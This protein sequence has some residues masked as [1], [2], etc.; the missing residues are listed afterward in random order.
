MAVDH[1]I[2]LRIA[3]ETVITG[4]TPGLYPHIPFKRADGRQ[5]LAQLPLSGT[6]DQST[7]HFRAVVGPV[8]DQGYMNGVDVDSQVP[9]EVQVRYLR[10]AGGDPDADVALGDIVASDSM[11]LLA[12]L[13]RPNVATNPAYAGVPFFDLS[14]LD[15]GLSPGL[16]GVVILTMR[17]AARLFVEV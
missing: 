14:F 8:N 11:T 5:P 2:P 3:F 9:V 4:L 1:A 6:A 13:L 7:R 12:G 17:F 15:S 16:E 10:G